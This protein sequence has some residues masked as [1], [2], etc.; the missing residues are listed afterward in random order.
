MLSSACMSTALPTYSV[1]TFTYTVNSMGKQ[2]VA[3]KPLS[4]PCPSLNVCPN[5]PILELAGELYGQVIASAI[6]IPWSD[7]IFYG[8]LYFVEKEFRRNGYGTRLRDQVAREYVG[9]HILCIDAVMGKV[10]E[11]NKKHGYMERF[12]TARFQAEAK[13]SYNIQFVDGEIVPVSFSLTK[14]INSLYFHNLRI[15]SDIP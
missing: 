5:I 8:S 11:T 4:C 15:Q 12:K 14:T 2:M 6:R 1:K 10:A 3:N 7:N 9:K 13:E